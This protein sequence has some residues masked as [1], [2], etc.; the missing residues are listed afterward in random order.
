MQRAGEQQEGEHP[1]QYGGLEVDPLDEIGKLFVESDVRQGKFEKNEER[2]RDKAHRQDC[3]RGRKLYEPLVQPRKRRRQ[4][5]KKGDEIEY[6]QSVSSCSRPLF[7][8]HRT[9]NK[10]PQACRGSD[11]SARRTLRSLSG[12]TACATKIGSSAYFGAAQRFRLFAGSLRFCRRQSHGIYSN[13]YA[14]LRD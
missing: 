4:H 8:K 9:W 13:L 3:D 7:P 5:Q 6:G 11:L 12:R 1:I 2:R 10:F 14:F